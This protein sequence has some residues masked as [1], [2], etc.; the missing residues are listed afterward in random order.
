MIFVHELGHFLAGKWRG[1]YIDRFQIWFGKP[2]WSKTIRGVRYGLGWIPAGGFVSLP[3]LE[4]MQAIEGKANIPADLKPLKPLDKVI[5][6]A[7]GPLFSLLLAYAFATVV[8]IIGKPVA[9]LKTTTV[10][11]VPPDTPAAEAGI[12]PGDVIT[13]V[14][15]Q[16]VT[17][18]VGNMEGVRELIAL[19]EK[20]QITFSIRRPLPDGQYQELTIPCSYR[21]PER[22]WWQ[23]QAMRQVGILPALPTVLAST[24]P[25]SPAA[26]A[27]L[28][29]GQRVVLINGKPVCN[30][31]AVALAA[32]EGNPLELSLQN[33]DGT[34]TTATLTPA[35]PENWKGKPAAQ[36]ILGINWASPAGDIQLEH[37]T[38]QAQVSQSLKWMGDTLAKVAAPGSSVGLEHLSGPVG[39]GSYLYQMM[40]VEHGWLLV[41]WF[42]VVLNVN[43]AVLNILP[44]PIVDGGHVVLGLAEMIRRKPV[45]GR[46]LDWVQGAFF[47]LLIF[48]FLFVTFKDV[49]DMVG[50]SAPQEEELPSPVFR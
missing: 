12:L 14:D 2:I 26:L 15:G 43:L 28:E 47:F 21:L 42:A 16:P 34:T 24:I 49:G 50:N 7:A 45:S 8:W 3:Q 35:I 19:S 11:Y 46:I 30:P 5:I 36:P 4:D 6:A 38:P 48:F 20:P 18:W 32:R 22:S 39:I 37:P 1:A 40:E 44:L 25:G 31:I 17:Q 13:A 9:D 41:L 23:R 29:A 27:G 33:P 10:G